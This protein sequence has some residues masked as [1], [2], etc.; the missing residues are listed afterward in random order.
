[1]YYLLFMKQL[2]IIIILIFLCKLFLVNISGDYSSS[3]IRTN[4]SSYG[5]VGHNIIV[6]SYIDRSFK[7]NEGKFVDERDGNSYKWVRIGNQIWMAENLK[8]NANSGTY[9]Y[10]NRKQSIKKIGYLYNWETAQKVA[11]KG[12]HLASEEEYKSML[13]FIGGYNIRLAFDSLKADR[14]GLELVYNGVY[15]IEDDKFVKG[16]FPFYSTDLWTSSIGHSMKGDVIYNFFTYQKYWRRAGIKMT[17]NGKTA[18]PIRC[19]KD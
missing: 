11:P 13:N 14:Y 17:N 8:F 19:V 9:I 5:I 15:D 1:M 12:W 10:K 18:M 3:E 7:E 4:H 2:M 6:S 16:L